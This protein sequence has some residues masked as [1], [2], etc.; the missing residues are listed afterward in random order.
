MRLLALF[1]SL[2]TLAAATIQENGHDRLDPYPGQA[3]LLSAANNSQWRAYSANAHE[4]SY[5]GRWDEKHV[6]WWAAPGLKF[7]FTGKNVAITFG[8]YTSPGVMVAFRVDGLDWQFSNVTANA[9]YQFVSPSYLGNST[10]D[11]QT[12]ELRVTNWAYGVQINKV[13]SAANGTLVKIPNHPLM[14]E[15]IGDS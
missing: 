15:F 11:T 1:S 3:Q 12:F 7:G 10:E 4:L 8:E 2:V 13:W 5:K 14:I 9:T 6:S